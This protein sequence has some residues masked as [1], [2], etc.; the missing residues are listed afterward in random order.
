[1]DILASALALLSGVIGAGFASGREIERFFAGQGA[2]SGA[3]VL[4]ALLTLHALFTRLP[5]QMERAGVSTLRELCRVRFGAGMGRVTAALFFL[6]SSITGGAMLAAC[7]ELAA[8]LLPIHHAY[9]LGMAGTLLLGVFLACFGISGLAAVGAGLC[10]L[11]PLLLLRLLAI[12]VGE[13]CFLPAMTADLPVR[14]AV[15]G[16]VYGALNAAMLVGATPL[17]LTLGREKRRRASLLFCALF[18]V[19]LMLGTAVCR[20]HRQ[21]IAMQ[22]LPFVFLSRSLGAGGYALVALCMYA[23]ALST[24]CAMLCAL[25][26]LLPLPRAGSMAVCAASCLAFALLGFGR[27][28]QS[29]YPVLGV[30]CAALMLL[31]CLPLPARQEARPSRR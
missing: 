25:V 22:P 17:L 14:A 6:L 26:R 11:L 29:A 24:L 23:A 5:A 15:D 18:G 13:A 2:M 30:L 4:C 3:A 19:L 20:Q 28:V 1:M 31:L 10:A 16:A 27:I 8:L 12:P 7:A 9:A 21:A